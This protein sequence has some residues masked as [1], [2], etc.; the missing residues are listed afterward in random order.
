MKRDY[1][2][3]KFTSK[4][5][6]PRS[7]GQSAGRV[8][9]SKRTYEY[10]HERA[11]SLRRRVLRYLGI[12]LI[13]FLVYLLF[14]S[15][16]F[17]IKHVVISGHVEAPI[18]EIE[19]VIWQSIRRYS[20]LVFP[21]DNYFFFSEKKLQRDFQKKYLLD[22]LS[23]E[24]IPPDTLLVE[25]IERAGQ[26]IWVT[27]EVIYLF[28]L[29]GEIFKEVP[30]R[31]MVNVGLPVIYDNSESLVAVGDRVLDSGMINFIAEAYEKF[32]EFGL[33]ATELDSFRVDSTK[34]NFIRLSTKQGFEIHLTP[35]LGL[36]Q[37]LN[38]LKRSLE[39]GKIDLNKVDYI[40]LRL[41]NQVI[42]K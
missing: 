38:K 7:S 11:V 2:R 31:E 15:E 24:K 21:Q 5:Q 9:R 1:S 41:D 40:N 42:Y 17:K 37:Q 4:A 3:S 20:W 29:D 26:F 33:P 6:T 13:I 16:S 36:D 14:Y 25:L 30:A 8:T 12:V 10:L 23:V 32:A 27:N 34:A 28:N 22:E 19:E 18:A 39:A 35:A